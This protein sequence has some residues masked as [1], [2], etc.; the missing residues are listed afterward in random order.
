[1]PAQAGQLFPVGAAVAGLEERR[2][3]HAGEDGVG[4]GQRWLQMPN[5]LELPRMRRAVVPLVRSR[6][7]V[8][9]KFVSHRGPGCPAVVGALHRLPEPAARL[10]NPNPVRVHRRAFH[11]VDLPAGEERPAHLPIFPRTIRAEEERALLRS[12]Q[13]PHFA[14]PASSI[15]PQPAFSLAGPPC[16]GA[17]LRFFPN[18]AAKDKHFLACASNPAVCAQ[19]ELGEN[20]TLP[21][22]LNSNL[23]YS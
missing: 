21:T 13:N 10:R 19:G 22:A 11:V 1:M 9:G 15:F 5:P 8:V 2:I 16:A 7:A 3:L 23:D 18:P 17:V 6:H 14:H 20:R 12:H 4:V